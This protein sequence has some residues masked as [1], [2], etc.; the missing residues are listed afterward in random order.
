MISQ[1]ENEINAELRKID[2]E[3]DIIE[4]ECWA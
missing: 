1:I 2:D 3:V 4:L